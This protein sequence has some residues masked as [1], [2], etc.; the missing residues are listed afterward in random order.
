MKHIVT[1]LFLSTVAAAGCRSS[2][3]SAATTTN[4]QAAPSYA[5]ST[6]A[7]SALLDLMNMRAIL[8][9]SIKEVLDTQIQQNPQ[10]EP[11][12]PAMTAF[13]AK[14]M[15]W[16][17]LR[18]DFIVMYVDTFSKQEMERMIVYYRSD[19]GQK[20]IQAIP[21]LMKR[22]SELGARRVQ[23]HLPELHQMLND[24]MK[25]MKATP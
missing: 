24:A 3:P 25:E 13:L 12:R 14:Y 19:V 23:E 10:I 6:E 11:F 15:S 4:A 8:A 9:Q 21:H 16:E 18:D 5:S 22:G 7:A 2:S 1:I 20:S 17:S